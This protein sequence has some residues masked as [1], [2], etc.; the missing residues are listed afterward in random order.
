VFFSEKNKDA[1]E[2]RKKKNKVEGMLREA[3]NNLES[4]TNDCKS[5][6]DMISAYKEDITKLEQK[7]KDLR[8]RFGIFYIFNV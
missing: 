3:K 7:L 6:E 8:V 2:E 4:R 1:D 5:I